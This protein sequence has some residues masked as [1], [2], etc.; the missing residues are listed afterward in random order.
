MV[1]VYRVVRVSP[2]GET[3]EI[4]KFDISTQKSVGDPIRSLALNKLAA[5]KE[6]TTR[7]AARVVREAI[8]ED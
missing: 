5:Y 8:T 3:A 1:G 2:N 6:D 7:A 4:E